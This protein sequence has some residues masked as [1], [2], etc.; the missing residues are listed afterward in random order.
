MKSPAQLASAFA[1]GAALH[2]AGRLAEAE[3]IYQQILK[4]QPK[5]FESRFLLGVI[6][7]QRG[8]HDEAVREFDAALKLNS[9]NAS[10]HNSRGVALGKLKRV[11]EA[12]ASFE[13]RKS[14]V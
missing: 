10:V 5:H 14:V 9:R 11:S 7:A 13:D 12:L 1:Q 4:A 2:Q 8:G 3:H 6:H